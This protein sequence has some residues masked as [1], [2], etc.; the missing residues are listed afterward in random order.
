VDNS[1]CWGNFHL[2]TDLED[3]HNY[4]AMPDHAEQWQKWVNNL[5]G[6]P[7]WSYAHQYTNA[8]DWRE[9]LR[10]PWQNRAREFAEEVDRTGLEPLLVSEF[11]NWGL[12]DIEKLHIGYGGE[13]WWFETGQSWGDGVVYPHGV[14]AR[15]KEYHLE[16]AFANLYEL[17]QASQQLQ[18][19]ALQYQIGQ[20][21]RQ[22]ALQGYV[23]TEFSDVHWESN[24]LLDMLRNPKLYFNQLGWLNADD[25]IGLDLLQAGGRSGETCRASFWLSHYSGADLAGSRVAWRLSNGLGGELGVPDITPSS[26]WQ[27]G[28]IHLVLPPVSKPERQTLFVDWLAQDGRRLAHNQVDLLVF[29]SSPALPNRAIWVEPDLQPAF[30]AAGFQL[31]KNEAQASIL[32]ARQLGDTLRQNLL[33]GKKILWLAEEPNSLQTYIPNLGLKNRA[34][35][36]WQGDW[37]S[38]LS[39][40]NRDRMFRELPGPGVLDFTFRDLTAETVLTGFSGREFAQRVQAA[41]FVGWLHKP[42]PLIAGRIVGQGYLLACSLRLSQNLAHNPLAVYLLAEMVTSLQA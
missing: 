40:L 2:V 17:T 25:F 32:V 9:F 29:P 21:R 38:S 39:W 14:Q 24:G 7:G 42:V 5:A 13:P 30:Q 34:G 23:I 6:R 18:F 36:P 19:A 10:D 16:R 35:S 26:V 15:Y 33:D 28:E 8:S 3:F 4:Y 1:A 22:A 37:A 12:P 20:I 11:G 31:A 27:D 41:L